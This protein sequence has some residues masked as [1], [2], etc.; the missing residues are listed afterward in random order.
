MVL[1]GAGSPGEINLKEH[2]IV[3]MRMAEHAR[4]SVLLVGD[5]DRGGVTPPSSERG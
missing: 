5:I 4:A 2:D 1:E 3:N